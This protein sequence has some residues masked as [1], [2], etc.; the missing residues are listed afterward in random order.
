MVGRRAPSNHQAQS[1]AK[2]AV[3]LLAPTVLRKKDSRA[4][5]KKTAREK[6]QGASMQSA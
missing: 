5:N 6:P 4:V 1:E 2:K 3:G